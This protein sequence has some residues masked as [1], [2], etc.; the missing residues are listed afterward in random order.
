MSHLVIEGL[1][2]YLGLKS[3][4]TPK[5]VVTIPDREGITYRC[6][7]CNK[8]GLPLDATECPVCYAE[9]KKPWER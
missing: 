3:N 8:G 7:Q 9:F 5:R 6:P 2:E 1:V 4:E